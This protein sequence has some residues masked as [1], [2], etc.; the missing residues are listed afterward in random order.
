MEEQRTRNFAESGSGII[1]ID[2]IKLH[3]RWRM[4]GTQQ[5]VV[6]A[7]AAT[8]GPRSDISLAVYFDNLA[9]ESTVI[10]E[11]LGRIATDQNRPLSV[12]L[13]HTGH[14]ELYCRETRT[15]QSGNPSCITL[16][17]RPNS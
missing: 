11:L 3:A 13:G 4:A 8:D 15:D 9:D 1:D 12:D 7:G 5:Y 10:G 17:D 16:A 2:G 14:R 6:G